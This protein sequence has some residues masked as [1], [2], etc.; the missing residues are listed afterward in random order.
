MKSPFFLGPKLE[1]EG[2]GGQDCKSFNL[3]DY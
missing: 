1:N 2:A 3:N